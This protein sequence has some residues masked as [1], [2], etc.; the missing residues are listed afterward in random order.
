MA[1]NDKPSYITPDG[2]A[3]FVYVFEPRE[4]RNKGKDPKAKDKY[5]IMLVFDKRA[6][7]SEMEEAIEALAIEK[8]GPK[9]P[10]LMERGKLGN[11]IRDAEEYEEYGEPF[12]PGRRMV[13][14][15]SSSAPGIVDESATAIMDRDEIFPGMKCR[16]S[17][18]LYWYDTDG[19]K[20]VGLF[21]N[22]IQKRGEGMGRISGRKKAEDEF[23]GDSKTKS[24]RSRDDDDDAPVRRPA[25][26]ATRRSRDDD[27]D[28]MG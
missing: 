18:G 16:V 10:Q 11:P 23:G 21:L 14:F 8:A 7:L 26:R 6:D 12:L 9:A 20:G 24:R 3:T 27:D 4:N 2:I 15:K 28:L 25:S 17:Y 19:N 5:S 22:N 13:S 1:K